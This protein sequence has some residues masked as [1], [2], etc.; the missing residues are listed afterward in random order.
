MYIMSSLDFIKEGKD[1]KAKEKQTFFSLFTF[2]LQ[3]AAL[4]CL[5]V[6]HSSQ[7]L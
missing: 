4:F 2:P 5:W 3:S 1:A 7:K 6:A